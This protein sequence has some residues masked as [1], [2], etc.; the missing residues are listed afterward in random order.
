[1]LPGCKPPQKPEAKETYWKTHGNKESANGS[2]D[3]VH[4]DYLETLLAGNGGG[5]GYIVGGGLT[6]AD[7]CVWEIVDLHMRTFR[8]Q[9]EATVRDK[10]KCERQC[11]QMLPSGGTCERQR[12]GT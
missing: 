1:M 12:V 6:A 11:M 4:F 9:M 5:T 7:L 2:T 10:Q 3:G 8:D